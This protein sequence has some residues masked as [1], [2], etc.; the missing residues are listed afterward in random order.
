MKQEVNPQETSRGEAFNLWMSSPQPMVTFVKT[1]N[2]SRLLKMSHKTGIKFNVLLC[3][4][5]GKAANRIEEFYMLPQKD[6]LFRYSK[7]ALNVIVQNKNGGLS[8]CDIPFSDDI[9]RFNSSYLELTDK[10]SQS[11]ENT[12]LDDYMIIGT[13]AIPHTEL[14]CIINQY[15][16]QYNNPF[17]AWGRFH[18]GWLKT[19]LPISFQFHH[20]QMD[21]AHAGKFLAN[22]QEEINRLKKITC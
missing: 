7:L 21:G 10:A 6:K 18:K 4:C 19:T 20:T 13:S 11:C 5:I 16:G 3:W 9:R 17:L 14:E 12:S 2:V 15:S 22:L 8:T 1:F